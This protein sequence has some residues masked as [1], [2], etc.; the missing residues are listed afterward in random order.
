[1]QQSRV[2]FSPTRCAFN[3]YLIAATGTL[4]CAV[5]AHAHHVWIEQDNGGAKFYFG[6]FHENRRE[7]SPGRLDGFSQPVATL[8]SANGERVLAMVKKESTFEIGTR[9]QRGEAL[10]AQDAHYPVRER[11][12]GGQSLRTAWTPAARWI[13]GFAALP[14]RLTL[15][16]VPTGR[17]G[18][19]RVYFREQPLAGAKVQVTATSGWGREL[20]TDKGGLV[21]VELPWKGLYA[22]L[23]RHTETTPGV[24]DGQPYA[25]ASYGTTTT[26]VLD[27]GLTP[28]APLR[29]AALPAS[30]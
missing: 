26:F 1:M 5:S 2:R 3:R 7:V 23:V 21:Y 22:V 6:E 9:T 12:E 14:P 19:F 17:T 11:K 29:A 25:A 20:T 15:D 8:L 18:E 27:A 16:V 30:L 4:F 28:P 10:I 24:R 13:N